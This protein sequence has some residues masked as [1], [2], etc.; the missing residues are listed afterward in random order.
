MVI[1]FCLVLVGYSIINH[2][3]I[4]ETIYLKCEKIK[5]NLFK[6]KIVRMTEI[7]ELLNLL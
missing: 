4:N 7:T 2:T 3:Q 6:M 1:D 5:N